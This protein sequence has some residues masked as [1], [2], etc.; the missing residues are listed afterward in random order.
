METFKRAFRT[1]WPAFKG[2]LELWVEDVEGNLLEYLRQSNLVVNTGKALAAHDLG[3]T[4]NRIG[5]GTNGAPATPEDV[6]P[7]TE[8]YAKAFASVEYPD[9]RSVKFAFVITTDEYVGKTIREFGLMFESGGAYTLF[10]R[11]GGFEIPKTN[12]IQVQ[13]SWTITF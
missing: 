10:A 1:I 9:Q 11:R 8:Q 3:D 2:T 4:V 6:A 5:I 7:L 13:G 12:Q